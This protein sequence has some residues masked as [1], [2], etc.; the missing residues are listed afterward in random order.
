MPNAAPRL[1]T[2]LDIYVCNNLFQYLLIQMYS[3]FLNFIT[4][5]RLN[6]GKHLGLNFESQERAYVYISRNL[7][8]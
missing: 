5:K 8:R 7:F 3:E 4:V 1:F 2:Y 6:F